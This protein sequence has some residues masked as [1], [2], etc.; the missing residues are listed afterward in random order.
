[1]RNLNPAEWDLAGAGQDGEYRTVI[2]NDTSRLDRPPDELLLQ[3]E[4]SDSATG[5]W[6]PIPLHWLSPPDDLPQVV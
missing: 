4:L 3:F 6:A 5:H 2:R 1:M